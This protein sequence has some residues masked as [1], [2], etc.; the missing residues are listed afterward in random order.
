MYLFTIGN[1]WRIMI[2]GKKR[3]RQFQKVSSRFK[4]HDNQL[5]RFPV[6]WYLSTHGDIGQTMIAPDNKKTK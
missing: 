6:I 4:Y 2:R 3:T 1:F 5:R